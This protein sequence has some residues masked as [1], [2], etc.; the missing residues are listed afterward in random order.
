MKTLI[1]TGG[2]GFIGSNFIRLALA[3]LPD[4]RLV[5]LDSL[6][7]AGNLEN[8]ADLQDHPRYRFARVDITAAEAVDRLF[9]H[10]AEGVIHFAA[11]SHVDRS[12]LDPNAFVL[13]NVVGTQNLINAARR[14][15][16]ERFVQVSTDEVY[17]S[18]G[19]S[20]R[21]TEETPLAPNSPYSASKAAGDL[22]VRAAHISGIG[23]LDQP[24]GLF[25]GIVQWNHPDIFGVPGISL[26]RT[27]RVCI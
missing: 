16:T 7:Y 9:A 12:V 25:L 24:Q 20:G 21:F 18:L 5:N 23:E 13:T 27:G 3:A 1:V 11:E 4:W 8:L 6:T 14:H 17:G 26:D 22:L 19:E 10:G 2:A 15:G